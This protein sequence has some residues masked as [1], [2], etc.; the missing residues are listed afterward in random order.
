MFALCHHGEQARIS[1]DPKP[2][3]RL[4]LLLLVDPKHAGIRVDLDQLADTKLI[5]NEPIDG[6]AVLRFHHLL[7]SNVEFSNDSVRLLSGCRIV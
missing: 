6:R 3:R 5:L 2:A 1:N 7:V 4:P